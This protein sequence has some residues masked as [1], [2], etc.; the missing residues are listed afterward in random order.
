MITN[1]RKC[2]NAGLILALII[3]GVSLPTSIISFTNKPTPITE[4]HNY[5]YNTTVIERYNTTI[6][7]EHNTTI[8]DLP[9]FIGLFIL[10]ILP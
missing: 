2:K 9:K 4:I 8:I 3:A 5:Y 10:L 7:E 1:E 6:I